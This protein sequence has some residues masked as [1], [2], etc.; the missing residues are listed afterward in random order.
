[1]VSAD[2]EGD[3]LLIRQSKHVV[4]L[5]LPCQ[6][7][8]RE[9]GNQLQA[10][11]KVWDWLLLQYR[12]EGWVGSKPR[13]QAL[14]PSTLNVNSDLITVSATGTETGIKEVHHRVG[15]DWCGGPTHSSE[16]PVP[17]FLF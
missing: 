3:H 5:L 1:M 14:G 11:R 10:I 12:L 15:Q 4:P 8:W 17:I 13:A 2:L 7:A 6:Q 16:N 9:C